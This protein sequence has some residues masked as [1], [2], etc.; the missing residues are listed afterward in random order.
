MPPFKPL[1]SWPC[2]HWGGGAEGP[3]ACG[4]WEALGGQALY[5]HAV[6]L[7]LDVAAALRQPMIRAAQGIV[8]ISPLSSLQ[9]L[10]PCLLPGAACRPVVPRSTGRQGPAGLFTA[11]PSCPQLALRRLQAKLPSKPADSPEQRGRPLGGPRRALIAV[12]CSPLHPTLLSPVQCFS[13]GR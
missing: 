3:G 11:V 13:S 10:L 12:P 7:G 6:W 9:P 2:P 5:P 8:G 1:S 4:R